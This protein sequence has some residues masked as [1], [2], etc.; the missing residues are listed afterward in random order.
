MTVLQK[1]QQA[2]LL[3]TVS[4]FTDNLVPVMTL[5]NPILKGVTLAG[6]LK[7]L[8]APRTVVVEDQGP[9]RALTAW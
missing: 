4:C 2:T 9:A 7:Y 6:A 5:Q 8:L 3:H 1:N